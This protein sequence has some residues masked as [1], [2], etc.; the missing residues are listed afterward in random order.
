MSLPRT[1]GLYPILQWGFFPAALIG[2]PWSIHWAIAQGV[3]VPVATYAGIAVIGLLFLLM[4]RILPYRAAWNTSRGDLGNDTTSALIAYLL[5]P[6]LVGPLYWAALAGVAAWLA[7]LAGGGLW[8]T[9][10]PLWAQLILLLLAGD[11]GRY[12]G[13]RLAHEVPLLWRFHAVHHSAERLWFF[14]AMRQHP[15]D[16]LWF[17]A[18]EL[19]VPILLGVSGEVLALYLA[20]TAVCG[21]TQHCNID[22]KLGPLYWIFNVGELHRWH[23]SQAIAES[24]HNYGNNLIVY[25]RLFGTVYHPEAG[26]EQRGVGPIGLLNPDYPKTYW[27]QFCAPFRRGQLDKPRPAEERADAATTG[28][29]AA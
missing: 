4:E 29:S 15:V 22:L 14:N 16:K 21:F 3:A 7:T 25:D 11:A 2:L 17:M 10:W 13:H 18:T 28:R 26:G 20:V 27:G 8:P 19:V 9:Q 6:K 12:W 5:I 1:H 24:D 23:H